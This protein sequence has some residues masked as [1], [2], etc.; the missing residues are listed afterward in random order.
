MFDGVSANNNIDPSGLSV[1]RTTGRSTSV[2]G[3]SQSF[4][5]DTSLV[6][7]VSVYTDNVSAEYG[8]FTGGVVDA[9]LKNARAD[10]WHI[11]ANYRYTKDDWAKYHLTD[12]Q[13]NTTHSTDASFQPEFNKYEY[14]AAL[15]G[16]IG[17]YL[18]AILSYGKQHSRIPLWSTYDVITVGGVDKERRVQY[19]DTENFLARLN[20]RGIDNLDASLTFLYSPYTAAMFQ[21]RSRHS[22]YDV[23]SGGF[24]AT[25]DMKNNLSFGVLK[26]S[27]GYQ[28][29]EISHS[30]ETSL[31]YRWNYDP[32]KHDWL[33][34]TQ[35]YEGAY[36]DL[37][38]E[39]QSFVY[40]GSIDFDDIATGSVKHGVKL[41]LEAELGKARYKDTGSTTYYGITMDPTVTG[42]KE[43]G[44]LEGSQWARTK[45]V[46]LPQD[47]KKNYST[48]AAFLEDDAH[49]E[50]FTIRPAVR[51]SSD[52]LTDNVD[53]APRF[54]TNADVLTDGS[55]NVYGGYNRYYGGQIL[56]YAIRQSEGYRYSRTIL[57]GA[58]NQIGVLSNARYDLGDLKTPY[59]DE[60]NVG[61]S[62][63]LGGAKFGLSFVDRDHRDQLK[64]KTRTESGVTYNEHTN[65]GKTDY[66]GVTLSA[67]KEFELGA[68][69]HVSELSA[70]RSD[71]KT[72]LRGAGGYATNEGATNSL[73]HVTYDG[74][75]T[76]MDELPATQFNSPW[77]LTYS[78][79]VEIFNDLRMNALLRYEKGGSG[80]RSVTGVTGIPDPD[81]APTAVY[82][83]KNYRD[84]C[85][86]DLSINYDIKISGHKL[87][88]GAE[89]LNI[90]N[91]K[92]DILSADGGSSVNSEYSMGRQYY[93][94]AR[95][96]F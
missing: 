47:R 77:V 66:W 11:T 3:E 63:K 83:K 26:N 69:K 32:T 27:I 50:R 49:I 7:S 61:A 59:S 31:Y 20:S 81:G 54:F 9:K 96:E 25:Y 19:R 33:N 16:P 75:L 48:F 28:Q 80:L 56:A 68:T 89:I 70:T 67:S 65:D 84:T 43:D 45:E 93:A 57:G 62:L 86:V 73:T 23:E 37:E 92:N 94:N 12:S 38:Q 41:G 35:S 60:Y 15:D 79:S 90:F 88:L 29:T 2:S 51:V 95:Y 17:D 13:Q 44:V 1:G 21:D 78:H 18:G 5:V 52:T 64:A 30:S 85:N 72:N 34:G 87:T 24:S 76:S 46:Y 22:S 39:K 6:E 58:W 71:T 74:K 40:K 55:F 82:E 10:R 91:R 8:G 4:F 14:N 42:S 53:V 36:G